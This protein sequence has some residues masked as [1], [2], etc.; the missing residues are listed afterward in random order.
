MRSPKFVCSPNLA[1]SFDTLRAGRQTSA[2]RNGRT[3]WGWARAASTGSGVS[4]RLDQTSTA[5][6]GRLGAAG[7]VPSLSARAGAVRRRLSGLRLEQFV[8]GAAIAA[9]AVL[10][11][12]P[13]LSLFV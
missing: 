11:V 12:L 8:M 3:G 9:L 5:V 10:V 6:A 7:A 2:Q 1:P 13:I 4:A